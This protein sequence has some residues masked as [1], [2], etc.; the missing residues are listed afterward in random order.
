MYIHYIQKDLKL[1]FKLETTFKV[2]LTE[3]LPSKQFTHKEH[4]FTKTEE[5]F[6]DN[7]NLNKDFKLDTH[8]GF[9]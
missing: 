3:K 2:E 9:S 7:I 6:R 5:L 4:R 8:H 1:T